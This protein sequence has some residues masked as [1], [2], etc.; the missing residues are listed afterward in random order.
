MNS[1]I[2]STMLGLGLAA[3]LSSSTFGQDTGFKDTLEKSPR[4]QEWVKVKVDDTRE[5]DAFIVFPEVKD[6]AA[7]VIVIHEIFGLSDWIRVVGD[8]LA[9]NGYVAICP[10]L[11]SGTGPNGGGTASFPSVDEVRRTVSGLNPDQVTADLKATMTYV[12]DLP[13]TTDKVAVT[14]FCWGGGKS[15]RLAMDEP[16]I[17]AALPYYGVP[18]GGAE[19]Y[20]RIACPVYGFYGE[21]DN[22]VNSTIENSKSMMKAA[23]K[24]YEPVI[25]PGAGHGFLRVG[26]G[27]GAEGANKT[28]ADEAWKRMLGLLKETTK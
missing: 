19:D 26:M 10:D 22:R 24:T 7:S 28:A 11:L 15:F 5:I 3:M 17:V 2:R 14:G 4:H 16:S 23:G 8:E 18:N 21:N 27:A 9:K 12:R 25:Y 13:A 6:P 20:K 1:S